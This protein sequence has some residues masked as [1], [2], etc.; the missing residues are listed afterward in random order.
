M[1]TEDAEDIRRI[2][3]TEVQEAL[4]STGL[5]LAPQCTIDLSKNCG[6]PIGVL[7]VAI[8]G[9]EFFKPCCGLDLII[10]TVGLDRK[11]AGGFIWGFDGLP[12]VDFGGESTLG[13]EDGVEVRKALL[14]SQFLN[15]GELVSSLTFS[16]YQSST[17]LT[18]IYP[19]KG[20][21]VPGEPVDPEV[22]G[23][24]LY[25]ICGRIEELG[26]AIGKVKKVMRDEGG[27]FTP[28][29]IA[30]IAKECG[31]CLWYA[32]QFAETFGFDLGDVAQE[33][34]EKLRSRKERGVLGGSGDAR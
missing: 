13:H 15:P 34:L 22:I 18:A 3:V 21:I 10:Q 17:N 30:E 19:G 8:K 7:A 6:C 2:T 5:S 28:E 9:K 1:S 25:V 11:Y 23:G 12:S 32:A 24:L 4:K 16:E 26:E 20:R 29:K 27:V 31:D 33:N 14:S